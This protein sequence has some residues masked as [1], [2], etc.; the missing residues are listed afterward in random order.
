MIISVT[1]RADY[2]GIASGALIIRYAYLHL[3][4]PF[5]VFL[6]DYSDG[7]NLIE[8]PLIKLK[9]C[10]LYIADLSTSFKDLPKV[11]DRIKRMKGC[12]VYWFDH[13]PTSEESVN[14]LKG[15]G[16]NLDL[17][18]DRF[19]AAKIVFQ[20]LYEKM[21]IEDEVAKRVS[22]YAVEADN[23]RF[24]SEETR[25]LMDLVSFYNYLD[26]DS[27]LTPNLISFLLHL[28][29]LKEAGTLLTELHRKHIAIYRKMLDRA[30]KLILNT[31][32][33]FELNGTKY[34]IAYSPNL[35]SG[36]QAADYLLSTYDVDIAFVVKED[37]T[38]SVRRRGDVDVSKIAKLF[39]GGGHPYAAGM[40]LTDERISKE[41]F[42]KVLEM[43]KKRLE[44]LKTL[45][46]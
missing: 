10:K 20:N 25:D 45:H 27:P 44:G 6:K 46:E 30:R 40:K 8:E 41:E 9:E 22:D 3:K 24:E 28:A 11:A 29:S 16:V 38:A 36:S 43:V 17:R 1:H 33:L 23:W 7:P 42:G 34:A 18:E 21:R 4:E 14:L 12:E 2:D 5:M 26:E 35:V 32:D 39:G 19:V 37:G 31:V 15:A 13:H